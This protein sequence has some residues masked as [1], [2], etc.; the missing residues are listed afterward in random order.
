MS[1][2]TSVR[3]M[4]IQDH[5]VRFDDLILR[6]DVRE[7]CYQSISTFCS[8]LMSDVR[9]A[10]LTSSYDVDSIDE[11]FH[12]ALELESSFKEIFIFKASVLSMREIDIMI[13]SAPRRVD[14]LTLCLVMML[15]TRGLR[16]SMFLPGLLVS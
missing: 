7:D 8:G 10:M 5:I 11:A 14:M 1:Y 2:T 16:M 4:S 13:T 6:C 12:L 9:R 15:T 3:V